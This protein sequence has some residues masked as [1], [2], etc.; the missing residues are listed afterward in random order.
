M[1]LCGMELIIFSDLFAITLLPFPLTVVEKARYKMMDADV[2]AA[3][4][5][6]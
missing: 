4:I 3:R 6:E 1:W 2:K 5:V